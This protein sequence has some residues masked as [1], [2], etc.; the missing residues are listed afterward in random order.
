M[1]DRNK[2][3]SADATYNILVCQLLMQDKQAVL[4]SL[5]S[6]EKQLSNQTIDQFKSEVL[7]YLEHGQLTDMDQKKFTKV[8]ETSEPKISEFFPSL[9]LG[10]NKIDLNFELPFLRPPNLIPC[11]D[12]QVVQSEFSLKQIDAPMPE[13]PWQ[14]N[15]NHS[16]INF[17]QDVKQATTV[18]F[19]DKKIFK[20]PETHEISVRARLR[21]ETNYK[22]EDHNSIVSDSD[23]N[24]PLVETFCSHPECL[25][26]EAQRIQ[27]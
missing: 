16:K 9:E 13:A 3:C 8:F 15:C 7:D 24:Q 27:K 6:L 14:K 22:K 23:D 4:Q 21:K 25:E 18:A 11:V 1:S 26:K 19:F 10:S 12:E 17:H 5:D 2:L 20:E